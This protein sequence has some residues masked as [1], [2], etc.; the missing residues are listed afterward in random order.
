MDK[1]H[2][3]ISL[4][5]CV[6]VWMRMPPTD[7]SVNTWSTVGETVWKSV[8]SLLEE[9]HLGEWALESSLTYT[10]SSSLSLLCVCGWRSDLSASCLGHHA[11]PWLPCL[12][13][14]IGT[15]HSGTI[16][17]NKPFLLYAAY[18]HGIHHSNIDT[19]NKWAKD[20]DA[21]VYYT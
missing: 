18:G 21:I 9:A 17:Q 12:P 5:I 4:R 19:T 14:M 20:N 2:F 7:R 16:S 13:D 15:K 8:G 10:A 6:V 1:I 11:F 3:F